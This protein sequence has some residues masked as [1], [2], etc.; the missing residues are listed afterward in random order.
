MQV[1]GRGLEVEGGIMFTSS[2]FN[3]AGAL[4]RSIKGYSI[5]G[6]R[7]TMGKKCGSSTN[8]SDR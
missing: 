4:V 3:S 7:P 6:I 8:S 5:P 2:A 1:V